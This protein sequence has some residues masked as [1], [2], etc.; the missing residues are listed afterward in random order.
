MD[1]YRVRTDAYS[2]PLDLLLYLIRRD[3]ID[4]Y[5]IPVSRVTQ[6]YCEYVEMLQTI[7]PNVAGEF[8]VMAATL[9]EIKSRLLLPRLPKDDIDAPEMDDPRME[10][11]RQLLEYRK[12]KDASFQLKEFA[13]LQAQRWSRAPVRTRP[14]DPAEVDL[15]DVQI[16]DLIGAFNKVMASIGAGQATHEVVY[17]DTPISLHAEDIIDR[18]QKGGESMSFET[19]FTGRS[20]SEMIGLF[21]ALLELMR[22]QRVR[23]TQEQVFSTISVQLLSA[24]PIQIGEEWAPRIHAPTDISDMPEEESIP[25][26]RRLSISSDGDDED[27]SSEFD[28]LDQIKVDVDIEAILKKGDAVDDS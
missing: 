1:D 25:S 15:N 8:L 22:Q 21:L 14:R 19:I 5:D 12:F 6:Q 18:L 16:W 20:K 10:L 28:E 2:G 9:M 4:V 3:E 13:D 17:D 27:E 11:V 26:E 7:D 24:E 23:I